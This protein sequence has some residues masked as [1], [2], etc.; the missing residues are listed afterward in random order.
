[1]FQVINEVVESLE[2]ALQVIVEDHADLP[3][4]WFQQRAR[5][6]WRGEKLIPES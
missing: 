3:E 4:G 2:G 5:Q 1:M 6:N